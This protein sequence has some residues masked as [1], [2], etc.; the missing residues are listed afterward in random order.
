ME[1][2]Q[3][4]PQSIKTIFSSDYLIPNFQRPYSWE[5]EQCEKL[6]DDIISF[7]EN[8]TNSKEYFLGNIVIYKKGQEPYSVI[9]GQQRL[10]TLLLLIKAFFTKAGTATILQKCLYKEDELTGDV[11][12][13]LR[14]KS[15]VIED[16]A[17]IL[18]DI[19]SNGGAESQGTKMKEN[20]DDFIKRIENWQ[21]ENNND[22]TVLEE[23]IKCFLQHVVLLP[24]VCKSEDDALIIFE[25]INNRG[26]SLSDSDIFKAKLYSS[27]KLTDKKE[28]VSQWNGLKNHDWL[29]RVLMHINRAKDG[30]CSKEVALR[31]YFTDTD[32]NR[33]HDSN[34]V[35][36]SLKLIYNVEYEWECTDEVN[37]LWNILYTCPNQYWNYP[38]YIFLNKYGSLGEDGFKLQSSFNDKFKKLLELT[39]KY[40]FIKGVVYNS[41]N[42][43]KDHVF[44]VCVAIEQEDDFTNVYNEIDDEEINQFKYKIKNK[45]YG[46]YLKG[47]VLLSSYLND[48]QNKKELNEFISGKFD[49][50]HILPNKWNNYDGWNEEKW[51]ENLNMIGN[52]IPLEKKLN[53]KA[54]NEFFGRKKEE[55]KKSKV[56]DAKDLL[57]YTNWTIEEFNN[58][59]CEK[60]ERLMKFFN[61]DK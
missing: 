41:V 31:T 50:E 44:K 24:I 53:I 9:D 54:S 27:D 1:A 48:R 58:L 30:D 22:P 46:K 59:Q 21:Q 42:K 52:L 4:T 3:A 60:I 15:E 5:K 35:M 17:N 38:L 29:F 14:I 55:Y 37:I 13:E 61:K 43:I 19:I 11:T 26:L 25:T 12:D 36:E 2:I 7:F 20:Y 32:K 39:I 40:F 16:D 57:D 56:Q 49:I 10:T 34:I 6:W 47:L 18:K 23:L 33:L 51:E 45:Q 8:R 28:F